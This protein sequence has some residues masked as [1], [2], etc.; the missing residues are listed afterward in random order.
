M[1]RS[2]VY[3]MI[4]SERDYQDARWGAVEQN[5]REVLEWLRIAQDRLNAA[6]HAATKAQK[7]SST[8]S[9]D[10]ALDELRQCAAVCIAALEQHGRPPAAHVPTSPLVEGRRG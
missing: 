3:E 2:K 5:P 6:W 1:E 8:I 10:L 4:D 9:S 7:K